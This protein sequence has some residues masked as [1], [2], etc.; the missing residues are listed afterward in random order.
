MSRTYYQ[1]TSPISA[2]ED[3]CLRMDG[4]PF[5]LDGISGVIRTRI[6]VFDSPYYGPNHR[7]FRVHHE[8]D[9][10]GRRH[11]NYLE[12]KR[13]LQDDH[14]TVLVDYPYD[15]SDRIYD[16]ATCMGI[17]LDEIHADWT[18]EAEHDTAR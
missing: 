12:V 16:I 8:P 10:R 2:L 6:D 14:S 18:G 4:R 17:D 11:P 9:E 5:V 13:V 1:S 15:V 3:L 7:T